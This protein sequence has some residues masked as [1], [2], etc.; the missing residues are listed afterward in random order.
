MLYSVYTLIG[1]VIGIDILER[2]V[3][4]CKSRL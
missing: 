2:V 1:A 3:L 4:W